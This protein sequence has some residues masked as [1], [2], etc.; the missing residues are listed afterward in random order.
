MA[1][2]TVLVDVSQDWA[3]ACDVQE[4]FMQSP[5]ATIHALGYTGRCRQLRA[6]GGD[7]YDLCR[8]RTIGWLWQLGTRP[9]KV[10]RRR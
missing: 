10:S 6:L 5:V 9:E 4:R 8:C 2:D 1:S 7:C 3:T